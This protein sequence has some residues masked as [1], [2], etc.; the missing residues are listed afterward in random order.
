MR[1]VNLIPSEERRG[2]GARGRAG[3]AVYFLL[4]GLAVMVLAAALYALASRQVTERRD[5]LG[6]VEREAAVVQAQAA[7]LRPY[8]EFEALKDKRLRTVSSIARSRFEW[9]KAMRELARVVP[10]DVWLT[11]FIGTVTTGVSFEGG[12]G[13]ETGALRATRATPAIE[14]VGCTESQRKVA[15]MM[16]RMRLI[17]GVTRVSLSSAE[18]SETKGASAGGS[19]AAEGSD[20]RQGD[21][22]FPLFKIVVFFESSVPPPPAAG[23]APAAATTTPAETTATTGAAP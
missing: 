10:D 3:N 15:L 17:D 11:S 4:G 1:A 21:T 16:T 9:S 14:L 19:T 6:R 8:T 7:A 20:C 18:K 2:A 5:K 13:G 12:G 23:T 22:R